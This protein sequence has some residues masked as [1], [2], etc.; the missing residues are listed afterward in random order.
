MHKTIEFSRCAFGK[1]RSANEDCEIYSADH[2]HAEQRPALF[3]ALIST[4][5]YRQM[6][7]NT[8]SSA[9]LVMHIRETVVG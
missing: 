6:T 9:M 4:G 1:K 5:A 2:G 7:T 3:M 8:I